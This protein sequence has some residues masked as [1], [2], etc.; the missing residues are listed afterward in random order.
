MAVR[1]DADVTPVLESIA[2]RTGTRLEGL[3]FRIKSEKSIRDKLLKKE[4]VADMRD[5]L[6]YTFI[7][8]NDLDNTIGKINS[9]LANAGIVL[10][11]SKNYFC[12]PNVYKGLNRT[13]A[14]N[15]YLFEIQFHTPDSFRLKMRMHSDYEEYRTSTS[16]DQRCNLFNHMVQQSDNLHTQY[17]Q[18]P[19]IRYKSPCSSSPK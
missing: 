18:E 11:K 4:S 15:D 6:R 5:I 14:I 10:K 13:Y 17:T 12:S 9:H 7:V 2:S 16:P 1:A 3:A 8:E 19:C